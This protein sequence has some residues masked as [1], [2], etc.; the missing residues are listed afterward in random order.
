L[1][2][3]DE[4]SLAFFLKQ[5]LL[6]VDA[7]WEVDTASTG[8]EAVVK[9]N[10]N[11]YGLIIAD[12]RMPGLSGLELMQM[13]RALEPD[14]RVILMTAYG[15]EKVE[16]EARRL[17]VYRYVTKPFRIED[18]KQWAQEALAEYTQ[19]AARRAAKGKEAAASRQQKIKQE[20]K[21]AIAPPPTKEAVPAEVKGAVVPALAEMPALRSY[22]S[23]LRFRMGAQYAFL[24]DMRG[25]L[26]AE[27]GV[28]KDLDVAK[29]APLLADGLRSTL[30]TTSLLG[31]GDI[32]ILI[33][34]NGQ[35][36]NVYSAC[37]GED[38]LLSLLFDRTLQSRRLES[39]VDHIHKALQDLGKLLAA[40]PGQVAEAP[41]TPV[42]AEPGQG[43]KEAV[44]SLAKPPA[45]LPSPPQPTPKG[46]ADAWDEA[47]SETEDF[48][49]LSQEGISFEEARARGLIDD[50][51]LARLLKGEDSVES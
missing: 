19:A 2:V 5:G 27:A 47:L 11:A 3:D 31:Q 50:D 29:L 36:Y 1:I 21:P 24:A 14:T 32:P 35:K 28:L 18:M 13:V 16:K 33:V 40:K 43:E 7:A 20:A 30:A 39:I 4:E 10:R 38:S 25:R 23:K 15:S 41:I 42:S 12:L 37:I 9:L 51:A 34:Q 6:E 48:S 46:R 45:D 8:E 17:N 26:W 22:L 44:I 49:S